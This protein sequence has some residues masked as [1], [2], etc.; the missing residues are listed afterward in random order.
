MWATMALVID[1]ENY[2]YEALYTNET[3]IDLTGLAVTPPV[4]PIEILGDYD[5][6]ANYIYICENRPGVSST[7]SMN[8]LLIDEPFLA[9]QY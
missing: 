8:S 3:R 4:A 2:R 7:S 1:L 6:G 9:Y 5:N